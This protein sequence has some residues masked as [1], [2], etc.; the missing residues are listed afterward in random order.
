M[1]AACCIDRRRIE[2][3]RAPASPK[4][5][6]TNTVHRNQRESPSNRPHLRHL[7]SFQSPRRMTHYL[8]NSR[9]FLQEA[10]HSASSGLE[11]NLSPSGVAIH[12]ASRIRGQRGY[13]AATYCGV[14]AYRTVG[15]EGQRLLVAGLAMPQLSTLVYGKSSTVCRSTTQ[16]N[17]ILS[18]PSHVNE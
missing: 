4:I 5:L 12:T 14:D 3:R 10:S 9:R 2:R 8:L 1:P 6:E 15:R 11:R 7:D 16:P 13:E 18:K 17:Q